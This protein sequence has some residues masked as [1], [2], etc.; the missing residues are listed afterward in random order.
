[1]AHRLHELD[2][3]NDRQYRM[4]CVEFTQRG[5]RSGEPDG[6]APEMSARWRKVLFGADL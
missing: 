5:Y 4:L 3:L 1:M 2:L 6:M